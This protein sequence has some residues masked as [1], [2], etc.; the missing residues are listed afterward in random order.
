M[1]YNK[2]YINTNKE[3]TLTPTHELIFLKWEMIMN[4]HKSRTLE[5]ISKKKEKGKQ[6]KGLRAL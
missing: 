2:F 1:M 3:W 5:E 4:T 6:D